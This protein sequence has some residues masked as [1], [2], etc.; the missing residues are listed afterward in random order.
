M[1]DQVWGVLGIEATNDERAIRKAYLARLPGFHPEEDPQ[2]FKSLREAYEA[3]LE[4]ARQGCAGDPAVASSEASAPE[5]DPALSEAKRWMADLVQIDGDPAQRFLVEPYETLIQQLGNLSLSTL[6]A[7]TQPTLDW[8]MSR[9]YLPN[10]VL[11]QLRDRLEWSALLPQYPADQALYLED[12]LAGLEAE[13]VF[14]LSSLRH[15]PTPLQEATLRFFTTLA[16]EY[17]R[18]N[19]AA[20]EALLNEHGVFLLPDCPRATLLMLRCYTAV[21]QPV[22]EAWLQHAQRFLKPWLDERPTDRHWLLAQLHSHRGDYP[23]AMSVL[24]PLLSAD[25]TPEI[26][27]FVIELHQRFRPEWVPLWVMLLRPG[28]QQPLDAA[29]CL[30]MATSRRALAGSEGFLNDSIVRLIDSVM[31]C[32]T[33]YECPDPFCF[34]SH[35]SISLSSLYEWLKQLLAGPRVFHGPAINPE[36]LK[37]AIP[38][39]ELPLQL[40]VEILLDHQCRQ[41]QRR[42]EFDRVV[43]Q[44]G[45]GSLPAV[46]RSML[47]QVIGYCPDAPLETLQRLVEGAGIEVGE[48]EQH[49]IPGDMVEWVKCRI[50][51]G[52]QHWFEKA[53]FPDSAE[54]ADDCIRLGML[55]DCKP[56]RL[57]D[58]GAH[59]LLERVRAH[60]EDTPFKLLADL[61]LNVGKAGSE[62]FV[63]NDFC[64]RHVN[65]LDNSG[66]GRSF[67]RLLRT[68]GVTRY[69]MQHWPDDQ[70]LLDA[71][72]LPLLAVLLCDTSETAIDNLLFLALATIDTD[73]ADSMAG[74]LTGRPLPRLERIRMPSGAGFSDALAMSPTALK[75][76]NK[77]SADYPEYVAASVELLALLNRRSP[78]EWPELASISCLH[79]TYKGQGR[80]NALVDRLL[81]GLLLRSVEKRLEQLRKTV[82]PKRHTALIPFWFG[83]LLSRRQFALHLMVL[84]AV[85]VIWWSNLSS[86]SFEMSFLLMVALGVEVCSSLV[87][88]MR[89]AGFGQ[90]RIILGMVLCIGLPFAGLIVIGIMLLKPSAEQPEDHP[91]FQDTSLTDMLGQLEASINA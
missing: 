74:P 83:G 37:A 23:G 84:L 21:E 20:V 11:R 80:E 76:V 9:R 87:R 59:G 44:A 52:G 2:G 24:R 8:A 88:R 65:T 79:R 51:L 69:V 66:L 91:Y 61:I 32:S 30:V 5:E 45:K 42:A 47:L 49:R 19:L 40:A 28:L 64:R 72:W 67:A 90:V 86:F 26:K 82:K 36:R 16:G 56:D 85:I 6:Y 3:A 29:E 78:Q 53:S 55:L 38:G 13:D 81:C 62:S 25:A 1:S 50:S 46:S 60:P 34:D 15:W 7:L 57:L 77:W 17:G 35:E 73:M 10:R 22:S 71:S 68:P 70:Q 31:E 48:P 39:L 89:D 43:D 18:G 58:P 12:F 4:M 14:D 33:P 54:R 63:L 75:S 27:S 41:E